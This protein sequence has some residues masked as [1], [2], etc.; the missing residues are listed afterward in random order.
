MY[1]GKVSASILAISTVLIVGCS[2][3]TDKDLAKHQ[4]PQHTVLQSE[5]TGSSL[6]PV[7]LIADN[8][9]NNVLTDPYILRNSFADMVSPVAIRPPALDLFAPQV[10]SE[11]LQRETAQARTPLMVHLGDALNI[12]CRQEWER[13]V[14]QF[15]FLPRHSVAPYLGQAQEPAPE[16]DG[17]VMAPGNHDFFNYGVTAGTWWQGTAWSVE[18]A[19]ARGCQGSFDPNAD[20]DTNAHMTKNR[21]LEE[22]VHLLQQQPQLYSGSRLGCSG[23]ESCEFTGIKGYRLQRLHIELD[24]EKPWRSWILQEYWLGEL[25]GGQQLRMILLDTTDYEGT[26]SNLVGAIPFL[27]GVNPGLNGQVR[28]K[29]L[30]ALTQILND[31]PGDKFLIMGH[32]PLKALQDTSKPLLKELERPEILAYFSAHTHFGFVNQAT[33]E[34]DA[35]MDYLAKTAT[36]ILQ[37]AH[38]EELPDESLEYLMT[39]H[40]MPRPQVN[41]INLG[42]VTDWPI[43]YRRLTVENRQL[44]TQLYRVQPWE[45]E[46][47]NKQHKDDDQQTALIDKPMPPRLPMPNHNGFELYDGLTMSPYSDLSYHELTSPSIFLQE[48]ATHFYTLASVISH[49]MRAWEASGICT[50]DNSG[51]IAT[52]FTEACI[53]F[54]NRAS[55]GKEEPTC[56]KEDGYLTQTCRQY[57][58]AKAQKLLILDLKVT[59]HSESRR[60]YGFY[61]AIDASRAEWIYNKHSGRVL[62]IH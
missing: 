19:W 8:Q 6:I 62:S 26:P 7:T 1:P 45:I 60:R 47:T 24:E 48:K 2:T 9:I 17:L 51:A 25:A 28:R 44:I 35:N 43:E 58:H 18:E 16:I 21:F 37:N 49:L 42:S 3:L 20:A 41:E 50:P 15:G 40:K 22:Y 34:Q 55:I 59:R 5:V 10:L 11:I 54:E 29:Q 52:P 57:M 39:D 14:G 32:H 36:L 12:A 33:P 61:R 30:S 31:H 4:M 38:G 53:E 46:Q 13:F 23:T 27:P 56:N